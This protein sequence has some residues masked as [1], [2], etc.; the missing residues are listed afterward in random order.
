[1]TQPPLKTFTLR[2]H[3]LGTAFLFLL[4]ASACKRNQVGGLE[5]QPS[6]QILGVVTAD[7]FTIVPYTVREDSLQTNRNQ[8]MLLGSYFDPEFG[9]SSSSVVAQPRL[10]SDNVDFGDG[11]LVCDSIVLSLQFQA[12]YGN[13]D[14]QSFTVYEVTESY[15]LDS[16]Y[17]SNRNIPVEATPIGEIN[18]VKP[19]P[20]DSVVTEDGTVPAQMRLP[21]DVAFGQRL[22]DASSTI[23]E[24]NDEWLEYFKGLYIVPNNTGTG[25][26]EGGILYFALN[27]PNS[28]LVLYFHDDAEEKHFDFVINDKSVTFNTFEHDYS[29]SEVGAF[30]DN[31]GV[32]ATK[33][34][35]HSMS[36]TKVKIDLPFLR[37]IEDSGK[38]AIVRAELIG[39]IDALNTV[40]LPHEAML[41][42][43]GNGEGDILVVPDLTTPSRF[44][45]VGT[46]NTYTMNITNYVQQVLTGVWPDSSLYLVGDEA[47]VNGNRTPLVGI[48]GEA[49]DLKLNISY[50]R[51]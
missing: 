5:I 14:A 10:S 24:S 21:L 42:G 18:L 47:S 8:Y 43:S 6:D 51:L 46:N 16:A 4:F 49:G 2:F 27:G 20:F 50:T 13:L 33:L 17:Y 37:H 30:L 39:T 9:W 40:Y 25:T 23:Y 19:N 34:F 36:G 29:N 28:K 11:P 26:G 15:E 48:A 3:V 7:T 45:G 22:L 38:I 32:A 44:D 1:M 35:V 31:D 41:L 12:T